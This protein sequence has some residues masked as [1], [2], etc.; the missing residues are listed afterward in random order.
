MHFTGYGLLKLTVLSHAI[1]L[2]RICNHKEAIQLWLG[3]CRCALHVT[4]GIVRSLI[5]CS[6][7]KQ[8]D[9]KRALAY[10]CGR[11]DLNE[12]FHDLGRM[13]KSCPS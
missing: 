3:L 11:F 1:C 10:M 7:N 4:S 12:T 2:R 6:F 8:H 5:L 13:Q 9:T